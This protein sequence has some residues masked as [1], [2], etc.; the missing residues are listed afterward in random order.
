[1]FS[2]ILQPLKKLFNRAQEKFTK[3]A[4]KPD[5][6]RRR[7]VQYKQARPAFLRGRKQ[8]CKRYADGRQKNP[9]WRRLAGL[10]KD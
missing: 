5:A 7:E 9:R 3:P 6:T 2:R 8:A 4:P 10:E 1:M